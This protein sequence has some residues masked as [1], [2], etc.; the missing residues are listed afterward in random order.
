MS[1][2]KGSSLNS[3]EFSNLINEELMEREKWFSQGTEFFK[4]SITLTKW[5]SL[6]SL[7]LVSKIQSSYNWVGS[8]GKSNLL[9]KIT[10]KF[11]VVKR[12]SKEKEET[13]ESK[14]L[15]EQIQNKILTL[16][17]GLERFI[18][19]KEDADINRK[20]LEILL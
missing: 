11:E 8:L 13:N 7:F 4:N 20:T 2:N 3:A 6:L 9:L 5:S 10:Q 19:L 15:L 12:Y 17:N 14:I 1:N 18:F 16:E